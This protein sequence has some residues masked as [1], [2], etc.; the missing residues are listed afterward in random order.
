[1]FKESF[2]GLLYKYPSLTKIEV[3]NFGNLIADSSKLR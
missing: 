3:I 1:M 2:K